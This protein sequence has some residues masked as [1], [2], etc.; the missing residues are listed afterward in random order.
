MSSFLGS[1]ENLK[2]RLQD[3]ENR[4]Y[5]I[6][7]LY[8]G[9]NVVLRGK[10]LLIDVTDTKYTA[11]FFNLI[12]SSYDDFMD[13][14]EDFEP[15][16][17]FFS[18]EQKKLWDKA[19]DYLKIYNRSKTYVVDAEV[20]AAV[21]GMNGLVL[22]G[23]LSRYSYYEYTP[24]QINKIFTAIEEETQRQKQRLLESSEVRGFNL[25]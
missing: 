13:F 17:K 14:S 22:L 1:A 4:Y 21:A 5:D 7:P 3:Y 18:G 8:P 15:V 11:E 24:A 6:Q 25:R 12:D 23:N 20:E 9:R 2:H 16:S 19:L 10:R